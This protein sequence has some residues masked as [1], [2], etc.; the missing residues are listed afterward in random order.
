MAAGR[1][2]L[3]YGS[4]VVYHVT[5]PLLF[6]RI[7]FAYLKP[8][9]RLVLET[10][11]SEGVQPICAYAGTREKG[12]NWYSPTRETLGRWLVDAGFPAAGVAIHRRPIGR[13]LAAATKDGPAALPEPAGFSRPGSW[14]E[15]PV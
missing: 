1:F 14:L 13:L 10:K 4:G 8:G 15:A 5:D 12:W 2:D 11:A 3:V 7:C 9:G 6:L